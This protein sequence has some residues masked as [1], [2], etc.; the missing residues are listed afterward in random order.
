MHLSY[1]P[2]PA[3]FVDI[4]SALGTIVNM[5]S[6]LFTTDW[7]VHWL[8]PTSLIF[9]PVRSLNAGFAGALT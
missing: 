7:T 4:N 6:S 1:M 2:V 8:P 9:S 5:S 3:L